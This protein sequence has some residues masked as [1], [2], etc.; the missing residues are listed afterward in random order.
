MLY[1]R[2]FWKRIYSDY[3]ENSI[4]NSY[5]KQLWN[6]CCAKN[7]GNPLSDKDFS[8]ICEKNSKLLILSDLLHM[9]RVSAKEL[10]S[11]EASIILIQLLLHTGPV[12]LSG[13]HSD[14]YD[15]M[16][17]DWEHIEIEAY[18]QSLKKKTEVIWMN[19][20]IVEKYGQMSFL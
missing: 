13:Y 19:F 8:H 11:P 17:K 20:D 1:E 7:G 10:N 9:L 12:L 18:A 4:E 16:L 5:R 14:L 3:V 6:I 15:I 2:R